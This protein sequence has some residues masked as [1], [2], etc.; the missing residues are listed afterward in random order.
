MEFLNERIHKV[1]D[2]IL[3]EL[4]EARNVSA[5]A[6][7]VVMFNQF[8]QGSNMYVDYQRKVQE[9]NKGKKD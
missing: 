4:E 6:D 7:A 2:G 8:L 1:L 9:F 5:K 3:G